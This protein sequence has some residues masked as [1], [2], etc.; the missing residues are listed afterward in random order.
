MYAPCM[1]SSDH[2]EI[3]LHILLFGFSHVSQSVFLTMKFCRAF[4]F[5]FG[6]VLVP[7]PVERTQA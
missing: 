7:F 3:K 5:L 4:I 2:A 1:A 6:I